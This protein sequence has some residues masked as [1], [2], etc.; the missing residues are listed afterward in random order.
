MHGLRPPALDDLGLAGAL[1][2][3]AAALRRPARDRLS[4]A[5]TVAAG[6]E[7][8]AAVE[9]AAYAITGEAL[10]N[11]ARHA[12]AALRPCGSSA[13]AGWLA[14]RVAD[15]GCGHA[16]RTPAR[17]WAWCRCGAARRSSAA[18]ST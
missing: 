17:A 1:R 12:G 15:D 13:A 6:A 7:L 4:V 14:V 5:S 3:L 11:A 16:V 2:E 10:A 8:P 18:P 9:V